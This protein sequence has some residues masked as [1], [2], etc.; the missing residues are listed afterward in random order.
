MRET[1]SH[2]TPSELQ[3]CYEASASILISRFNAS[4]ES[5][6]AFVQGPKIHVAQLHLTKA[7]RKIAWQCK[8]PRMATTVYRKE[9]NAGR[10]QPDLKAFYKGTATRTW[11]AVT[12]GTQIQGRERSTGN[13]PSVY[14]Q[15]TLDSS[16]RGIQWREESLFHNWG[17][18]NWTPIKEKR[19]LV[20]TYFIQNF[21]QN[22]SQT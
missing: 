14:D 2:E 11:G 4:P 20:L 5:Q 9:P 10:T 22:G 12:D 8:G 15:V 16:V 1:W 13:R 17:W 18:N 21:T 6:H 3:S 7:E 19:T